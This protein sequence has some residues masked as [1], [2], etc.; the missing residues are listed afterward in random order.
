MSW[1]CVALPVIDLGEKH[2]ALKQGWQLLEATQ[3][4][5]KV[6]LYFILIIVY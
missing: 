2:G 1:V 6:H 5:P 3:E 4:Y